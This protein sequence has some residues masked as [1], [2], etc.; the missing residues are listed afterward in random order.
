MLRFNSTFYVE[1][2]RKKRDFCQFSEVKFFSFYPFGNLNI[3]DFVLSGQHE[4]NVDEFCS[5]IFM[6]IVM[7]VNVN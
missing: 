4:L 3:F 5:I 6:E 7:H 2:S 1:S